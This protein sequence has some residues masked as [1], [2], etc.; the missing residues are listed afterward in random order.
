MAFEQLEVVAHRSVVESEGRRELVCVGRG[1][2]Q[3]LENSKTVRSA[4]GTAKKV[5]H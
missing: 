1:A 5:P 4:P 3:P 2:L